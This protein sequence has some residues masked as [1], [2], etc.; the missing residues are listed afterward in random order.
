MLHTY[1]DGSVLLRISAKE[2]VNIPVWKGNRILDLAHAEKIKQG[3]TNIHNLDGSVFHVVKY[4]ELDAANC[5]IKQKY[6]IDGQHRAHVIRT[7]FQENLCESDFPVMV[8]EKHVDS[9]SDAIDF[10]NKLNNVKAQ[11]WNHDPTLLGNK[12]IDALCKAF[13]VDKKNQFI[14][15]GTTKRPYLS[16]DAVRESLTKHAAVLKQE[17]QHIDAFVEKAK[18]WNKKTLDEMRFK[19]LDAKERKNGA[20]LEAAEK[21]GFTLAYD[22]KL[23]WVKECL[24]IH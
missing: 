3:V 7:H 4:D 5:W 20:L 23:P 9:E 13:N 18:Q 10:F 19:M 12:Y 6:L 2:L 1:S 16:V 21:R 15:Q 14:R 17:K 24:P 11:Q 22:I 8:I